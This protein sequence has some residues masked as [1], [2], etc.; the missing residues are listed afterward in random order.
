MQRWFEIRNSATQA[1]TEVL[2]FDEVGAYG[3][4]AKDFD[5]ELKAKHTEGR[6]LVVRINSPGGSV[7]DGIAIANMIQS[8]SPSEARIEGQ[9]AS[10]ASVI[11][12][13]A[14]RV[15]M[16]ANG[17]MMIHDPT[18]FTAGDSGDHRKTADTLDKMRDTIA[19]AYVAKTGRPADEIRAAMNDET[20]FDANEAL[21]WGLV[22]AIDGA[23]EMA[24]SAGT[25]ARHDFRNFSLSPTSA[26]ERYEAA[27]AV[28]V[29]DGMRRDLA[30]AAVNR[31]MPDVR[32][33]YVAEVNAARGRRAR[34]A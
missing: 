5:T 20:W 4:T 14:D 2:I 31:E 26:S 1:E 32:R 11:A 16:A 7:F 6:K 8:H 13:S 25:H 34:F 15:T 9:A 21:A 30:R 33:S 22:D 17:F 18:G 23:V 28:K 3:V 10:I 24:A 29:R 27:I 19:T 12:V